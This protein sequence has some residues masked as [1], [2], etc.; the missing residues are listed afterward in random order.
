M[1]RRPLD[2]PLSG[3]RRATSRMAPGGRRWS[4]SPIPRVA[5]RRARVMGPAP[6]EYPAN[7]MGLTPAV[8]PHTAFVG[9]WNNNLP[10]GLTGT[11]FL[12]FKLTAVDAGTATEL[13]IVVKEFDYLTIDFVTVTGGPFTVGQVLQTP[14]FSIDLGANDSA[15]MQIRWTDGSPYTLATP[16]PDFEATDVVLVIP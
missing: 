4:E 11:G 13:D 9:E 8:A 12:R 14:T 15:E 6:V 7:A 16:T 1:S 5:T 2:P 10:T 3:L